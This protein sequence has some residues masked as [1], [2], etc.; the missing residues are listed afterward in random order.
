MDFLARKPKEGAAFRVLDMMGGGTIAHDDRLLL[1][2]QKSDIGLEESWRET[3]DVRH[4]GGEIEIV[5]YFDRETG[6]CVSRE[7]VE[8]M[9]APDYARYRPQCLR[10]LDLGYG[11]S[12]DLLNNQ[13]DVY[14]LDLFNNPGSRY[15]S[16]LEAMLDLADR[17]T[18]RYT[19]RAEES[20]RN[21]REAVR[22][23]VKRYLKPTEY[24]HDILISGELGKAVYDDIRASGKDRAAEENTIYLRGRNVEKDTRY[25]LKI[26]DVDA[27]DGTGSGARYKIETTLR[28]AFFKAEGITV[29]DMTFQPDIQERICKELEKGLSYS[30]GLLS[31]ETMARLAE[32]VG[33]ETRDR[34]YMPKEV[35]RA[36]LR[37][38]RTLTARVA[39]LERVQA[40]HARDIERLKKATGLK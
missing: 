8:S 29:A 30:V 16:A 1:R 23:R 34:C 14:L 27:R 21:R 24:E 12:V 33:V 7:Y 10:G 2:A 38:E 36:M 3:V 40:E 25:S 17:G 9:E 39:E 13:V 32:A 20:Q 22:H 18:I 5:N 35:A 4:R 31:G 26:Y 6:S 37:P 15:R 19:P 11:A 28:K